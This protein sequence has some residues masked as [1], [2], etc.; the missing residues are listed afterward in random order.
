M[1]ASIRCTPIL[2]ILA[3]VIAA[4]SAVAQQVLTVPYEPNDPTVPHPTYNG[5]ATRFKAIARGVGTTSPY[6][7][8]DIDGDGV[9]DGCTGRTTVA[10]G[11]WYNDNEYCLDCQATLP[12]VTV[13]TMFM[14]TV[15]VTPA[16]DGSGNPTAPSY[17]ASYPVYVR[18]DVPAGQTLAANASPD[19]LEHM[20]AV[21]LDDA[22]WYLHCQMGRVGSGMSSLYG[23]LSQATFNA[24]LATS[25]QFLLALE[26]TGHMPAY[27]TGTY[28]EHGAGGSLPPSFYSDNDYRWAVDPYAEDAVRLFNF[29]MNQIGGTTIPTADEADDGSPPL[30]GTNDLTGFSVTSTENGFN[31]NAMC[32][33]AFARSGLANTRVQ[34]GSAPVNAQPPEYV[35]QQMVDYAV[36]AQIDQNSPANAIGGWYYSPC[37]DCGSSASFAYSNM[38][39]GWYMALM[40]AEDAMGTAGVYV[41]NRVKSRVPNMLYYNRDLTT[42]GPLYNNAAASPSFESVGLTLLGCQW[43]G[44]DQ[45]SSGDATPAG[46][47]WLTITRG[48]ARTIFDNY[49]NYAQTSWAYNGNDGSMAGT[50][51]FQWTDA[52]YASMAVG[53][54]W[55]YAIHASK[56]GGDYGIPL[57]G[58]HDW[59]Q[60]FAVDYVATQESTG[61]YPVVNAGYWLNSQ[62]NQIGYTSYVALTLAPYWNSPDPDY[63]FDG[64]LDNADNCPYA[65]NPGQLDFDFD[66]DGDVCDLDADNDGLSNTMELSIGTNPLDKDSDDDTLDDYYEF[67]VIMTD[68]LLA[69]TDGDGLTDDVEDN[70]PTMPRDIDT[71]D[72]GIS[73]GDED[74]DHDGT[75]DPM[76]TDPMNSDTDNDLLN[77]G[78]ESG[79]TFGYSG[80]TSAGTGV[81]IYGT[82]GSWQPD[83]DNSTITD[84]LDPDTDNDGLDDGMEDADGNGAMNGSESDPLDADTDDDAVADGDEAPQLCDPLMADSDS[85]GLSD[86]LELGSTVGVPSGTSSGMMVPYLGTGPG[87]V[88]DGDGGATTTDPADAD[89]DDDLLSDGVEDAD[90]DGVV[91]ISETDPNDDDSDDDLLSDGDEVLSVGSDPLDADTDDDSVDDYTE[92]FADGGSIGSPPNTD[93]D[94]Y[95][96]FADPDDDD[97]GIATIDE[98][99]NGNG[100]PTDDDYDSDGIADYLDDDDDNDGIANQ[101]D[102]CPRADNA[103]QEDDDGDTWGDVCDNCPYVSNSGQED[104]DS[105]GIGDVCETCCVLRV[106]DANSLGGDEP[107]IGDVSV[108]IDAKFLT[109]ICAGIIP[110]L[111][112][113]D[114]NLSS[115]G[116]PTCNDITIGDISTLID[117]LFI[118]GPS[119]GLPDCP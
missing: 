28:N 36:A 106:G 51:R 12:T 26:N 58:S 21:A 73:D 85:D 16:V 78:L 79:V 19:Q 25:S 87:F 97:D 91:D 30:S 4:T 39:G 62:M 89:T 74:A 82:A 77:D 52:N 54:S 47:P 55:Y 98:D 111:A 114:I 44:W 61:R 42:G 9:W 64:I 13:G 17:Y 2:I 24:T 48:Q 35:V 49:L 94:A 53:H 50:S 66:G 40:T 69:D 68:P 45:W 107:T 95:K 93:G 10:P 115:G 118:T 57:I 109:G 32:L 22:L 43:L 100:D 113:A 84:A 86:G 60:E 33:A 41:N 101:D 15:Q 90:S 56:L 38:S 70:G 72:D 103:G 63:D 65:Y 108:M 3:L 46:Y 76:E 5:H 83:T 14:A 6:F 1:S 75:Y 110:C 59:N 119:L 104:A 102:N 8:W 71:D 18:A 23:Y 88:P 81:P 80:G 34:V 37:F 11:N 29:L 7:R 116:S 27:P 31:Q 99:D 105:D 92:V 67:S 112:E 96:N 117:Y 20:K